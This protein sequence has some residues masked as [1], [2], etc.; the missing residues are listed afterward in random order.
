MK[1]LGIELNDKAQ[2]L[3]DDIV[4]GPTSLK[5]TYY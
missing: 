3:S 4:M 2:I 1:R 5:V